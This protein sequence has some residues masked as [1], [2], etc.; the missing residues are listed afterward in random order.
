VLRAAEATLP[1][2]L[3]EVALGWQHCRATFNSSQF[4]L[5]QPG[6]CLL[7]NVALCSAI[8]T[9]SMLSGSGGRQPLWVL[10]SGKVMYLGP[11]SSA[12]GSAVETYTA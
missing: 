6:Q 4:S 2:A 11:S 9:S 5:E 1:R 8:S 7:P 10:H 3:S 12:C